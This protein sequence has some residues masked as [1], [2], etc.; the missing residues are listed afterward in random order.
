MKNYFSK[1][2]LTYALFCLCLFSVACS[3]DDGS[4]DE[5]EGEYLT[6]TVGGEGFT[7]S[8]SMNVTQMYDVTTII[9]A[10]NNSGILLQF[11]KSSPGTYP[12]G[13]QNSGAL[14]IAAYTQNTNNGVAAWQAPIDQRVS[15][16][17]IVVTNYS[18]TN[19]KG[20]FS[21]TGTNTDDNSTVE[22]TNGKFNV[23]F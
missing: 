14:T 13:G 19:I 7:S 18:E 20:T 22:V 8:L 4:N 21:F 23:D 10:G 16:G 17:Q 1:L 12:I 15:N 2:S 6:A 9:G 3:S 11:N 5:Q